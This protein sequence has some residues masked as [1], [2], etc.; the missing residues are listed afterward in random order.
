[1]SAAYRENAARSS[2][3]KTAAGTCLV[4]AGLKEFVD[5]DAEQ[6]YIKA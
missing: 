6:V 5:K 2:A 4:Q 3:G 1:M